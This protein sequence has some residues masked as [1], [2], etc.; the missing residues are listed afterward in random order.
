MMMLVFGRDS[1]QRKLHLY[2]RTKVTE[3]SR[4]GHHTGQFHFKNKINSFLPVNAK[5]F[6][7]NEKRKILSNFIIFYGLSHEL[8]FLQVLLNV[9]FQFE[10]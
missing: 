6:L 7:F 3:S 5:S 9:S 2:T 8:I 10:S 4:S 1:G